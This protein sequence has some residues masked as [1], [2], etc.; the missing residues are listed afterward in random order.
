[1]NIMEA[2]ACLEKLGHP[3]RLEV[4]RLLVRAGPEGLSV[5]DVQAHLDIPASTLSHHL[6]KLQAVGLLE[7]RREG[8]VLYCRPNFARM[9]AVVDFLTAECCSGVGQA[10]RQQDAG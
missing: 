7:Q 4:F 1:M 8:R 3:T 2:A 5:G 9:Q 10:V 6:S